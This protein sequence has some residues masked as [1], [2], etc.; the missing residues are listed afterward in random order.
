MTRTDE[1][2]PAH[3]AK[4]LQ[5][6]TGVQRFCNRPEISSHTH[7]QTLK[8]CDVEKKHFWYRSQETISWI[9]RKLGSERA[10]TPPPFSRYPPLFL[11]ASPSPSFL[12]V[13][14]VRG[15]G[16]RVHH[17]HTLTPSKTHWEEGS[18]ISALKACSLC[19]T[20][21]EPVVQP[22]R[23]RRNET[24]A[25]S[26]MMLKATS[27]ARSRVREQQV[28]PRLYINLSC[29]SCFYLSKYF[30]RFYKNSIFLLIP[31][32]RLSPSSAYIQKARRNNSAS[33]TPWTAWVKE[34]IAWCFSQPARCNWGESARAQLAGTRM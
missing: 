26:W 21:H 5:G 4:I 17:E 7:S 16:E 20:T 12:W 28:E 1:F 13:R 10:E 23:L 6:V 19:G 14:G 33:F 27:S 2:T 34:A 8:S 29:G 18:P 24:T 30:F 22:V 25:L 11:S 3:V 31:P 9:L 32:T 15:R